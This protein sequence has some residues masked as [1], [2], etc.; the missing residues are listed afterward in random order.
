MLHVHKTGARPGQTKWTWTVSCSLT[1][2]AD[3][4][5]SPDMMLRLRLVC[6]DVYK[7]LRRWLMKNL[8][9]MK[10]N[11]LSYKMDVQLDM[12]R[13]DVEVLVTR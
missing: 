6:Y 9:M 10:E 4:A 11:I 5:S 2:T 3:S 7:L 12:L 13:N 8:D 1:P